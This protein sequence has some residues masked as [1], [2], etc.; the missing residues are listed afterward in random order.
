MG[1]HG[2]LQLLAG[3]AV[4]LHEA[5]GG[6]ALLL[7][8]QIQGQLQVN[9]D[10]DLVAV[11]LEQ[12]LGVVHGL[13]R[14]GLPAAGDVGLDAGDVVAAGV[15]VGHEALGLD[16]VTELLHK[17]HDHFHGGF[18]FRHRCLQGAEPDNGL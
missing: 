12:L 3:D 16:V 14:P 9:G 5:L 11:L 18:L 6:V 4:G 8:G 17:G 2:D 13:R 10:D 15:H 1:V 7:V